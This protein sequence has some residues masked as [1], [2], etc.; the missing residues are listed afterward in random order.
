M[1]GRWVKHATAYILIQKAADDP[2]RSFAAWAELLFGRET[3]KHPPPGRAKLF[4]VMGENLP[5]LFHVP[6]V[7]VLAHHM[8]WSAIQALQ[9]KRFAALDVHRIA[10]S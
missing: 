8:N 9:L 3:A 7:T 2:S 1:V 4:A 5:Y 10:T 6:I